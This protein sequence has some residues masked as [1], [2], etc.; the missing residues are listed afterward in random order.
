MDLDRGSLDEDRHEGLDAQPVE[1]GGA[2]QEDRVVLD[3]LLEDVPDGRVHPLDDALRALDVVGEALLHQLAHHERLE[4]LE[5]HLLGQAALVELELRPDHDDGAARV[6]DALAEQV[7]AEPALLALEH[8]GEALEAVVPGPGDRA[9]AAAVVHQGVAR[10]LQHPLLVADDDLGGTQLKEP[11]EPVVAV[12]DAP[13]EVVEIG[14]R[15]AAAVELHHRP[16]LGREHRQHRQDHPLGPGARAT[17][18]LDQAEPLDRLLATLAGR[19]SDLDVQGPTKLLELHPR[20][21]VADGLRAHPGPEDPAAAGT[22]PGAVALVQVAE[23]GLGERHERLQALDLV[24]LAP[25]LV[26]AA[27][28]RVLALLAPCVERGAHLDLEI[29]DL[30]LRCALLALLTETELLGHALRFG[31]GDL[32]EPGDGLLGALLAGREDHLAGGSECDG[33]L[34]DAGL[35]LGEARLDLL[36]RAADLVGPAGT[37]GLEVRRRPCRPRR[38]PRPPRREP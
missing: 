17:E 5:G 9:P 8:V 32:A 27:L 24:A 20:D 19:G 18:R 30:L 31:R 10:L 12:D 6:V 29:G 36:C 34:G 3:D 28:G 4:Q 11:L 22:R 16:Q 38:A 2:V 14:G 21:D 13:V 15:E 37:L 25:D 1:R 23:V 33:V 7:L 26:L 35:E